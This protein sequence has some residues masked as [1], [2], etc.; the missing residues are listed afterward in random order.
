LATQL[1]PKRQLFVQEYLVDLNGTQAA[2]RAGYAESG[3]YHEAYRLLRNAEVLQAIEYALMERTGITRSRIVDELG[4]IAFSDL[5]D[6]VDWDNET[7]HV[8]ADIKDRIDADVETGDRPTITNR[9][10]LKPSHK[11]TPALRRAVAKVSQD[12]YGNVRVEMHD[13]LAALDKL[14]RALGMYQEPAHV[15]DHSKTDM[16]ATIIYEGRADRPPRRPAPPKPVGGPRD[17]GD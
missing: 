5:G 6:F 14:A 15:E 13:K 17:T 12:R 3:A 8:A 11:L 9:V 4:A 16:R 1:T 2:I 7:Q 10:T